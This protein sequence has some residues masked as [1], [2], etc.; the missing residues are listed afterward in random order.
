M[1]SKSSDSSISDASIIREPSS[2]G[3]FKRRKNNLE[4]LKKENDINILEEDEKGIP[5][6]IVSSYSPSSSSLNSQHHLPTFL[7]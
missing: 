1:P 2:K 5:E 4:K 3:G 6:D 7:E